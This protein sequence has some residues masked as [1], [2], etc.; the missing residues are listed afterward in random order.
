MSWLKKCFEIN[1]FWCI[2]QHGR[3]Q[4]DDIYLSKSCAATFDL[5]K[6]N[7]YYLEDKHRLRDPPLKFVVDGRHLD[8][9]E[10]F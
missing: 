5:A 3:A 1:I 4:L 8:F 2:F 10:I 7:T 6:Y 9:S